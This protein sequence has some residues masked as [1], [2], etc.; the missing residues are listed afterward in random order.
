MPDFIFTA[1]SA[2]LVIGGILIGIISVLVGGGAFFS[3]PLIQWLFPGVSLGAIVGNIKLGS[4]FRSI[5]ST[6]ATHKE[7]EYRQCFRYS[8]IA[9]IGTLG[10]VSI[11]HDLSQKWLFPIIILAIIVA[12]V[13]PKIADRLGA[14]SFNVA[15]LFIGFYAGFFGAGYGILMIALM[16]LKYPADED[17]AHVKIQARFIEWLLATVAVIAHFLHGNLIAA[18]WLPWATGSIIGGV[19]GGILL[20]KLG[21]FSGSVQ[22]TVLYTSFAFALIVAGY[23]F[24]NS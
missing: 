22:K 14:K 24:F 23:H 17:I 8:I 5:G 11:I 9:I 18:I 1:P 6:I 7:I 15:S 3:A 21:S 13:A 12:V 2:I 16:R 4:F 10:G 20:K 19:I